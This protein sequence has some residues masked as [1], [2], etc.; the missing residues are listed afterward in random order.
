M[1]VI[2]IILMMILLS[3]YYLSIFP[4]LYLLRI[5]K[6]ERSAATSPINLSNIIIKHFR[7]YI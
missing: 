7:S 2:V 1:R 4:S 5:Y 6:K 3:D